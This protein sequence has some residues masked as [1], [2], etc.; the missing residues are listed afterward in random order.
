MALRPEDV[1]EPIVVEIADEFS[2][3]GVAERSRLTED[4]LRSLRTDDPIE[5]GV[6]G[7]DMV[8][9]ARAEMGW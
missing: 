5:L 8:A 7:A 4:W 6:T 1:R 3:A 9:E 2:R